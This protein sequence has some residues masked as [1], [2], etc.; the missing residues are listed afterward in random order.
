LG[1]FI[2]NILPIEGHIEIGAQGVGV[3]LAMLE[4][5]VFENKD[6]PLVVGR[7]VF[8]QIVAKFFDKVTTRVETTLFNNE[9]RVKIE[10]TKSST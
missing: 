4:V 5:N 7:L 8:N 10:E 6:K 1:R 2:F 3:D 9:P